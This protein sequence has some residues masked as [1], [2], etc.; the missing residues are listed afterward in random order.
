MDFTPEK[1]SPILEVSLLNKNFGGMRTIIDL[2]FELAPKECLGIIGPNGAGKT[3]L[4]NLL[5][6]IIRPSS[7]KILWFH[8]EIQRKS[9]SEIVHLGIAR[10]FQNIRLFKQLSVLENIRI[11]Y[12]MHLT[13]TPLQALLRTKLT[14][15]EEK[16][17]SQAAMELLEVFSI[18]SL[19]HQPAGSLS[20]G[21][22]RRLEIARA[23]ALH[24][25][26]LLLDEPAA[27]MNESEMYQLVEL[28]QW[29]QKK[30]HVSMLLI[31]HHMA[32]INGLCDRTLVLD[33]GTLIAQG[34]LE[35]IRHDHRVIEAYLGEAVT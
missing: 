34:T 14:R 18:T 9:S 25:R 19:A 17:S 32:F 35:E 15:E 22:Q 26:L 30:F 4:F 33:F 6:G 12:D 29:I 21:D 3:T 1:Q 23:L 24:P 11:A 20:Y 27:G 28:L 10:T 8:Q 5:S 7:G 13:Y 31:E 2:S 16:K